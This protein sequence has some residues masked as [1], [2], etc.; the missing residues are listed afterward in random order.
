MAAT[1]IEYVMQLV[2]K[3]VSQ[4]LLTVGARVPS[5][6]QYAQQLNCSVSTVVEAY[7][8]LVSLGVLESRIGAGYFVCR[9]STASGLLAAR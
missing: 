8:R 7:A 6:R 1:K 2:Q 9:P 5:V 4:N 3:Q